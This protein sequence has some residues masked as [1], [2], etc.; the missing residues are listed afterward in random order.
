M[1]NGHIA[2]A[3]NLVARLMDVNGENSFRIKTYSNASFNIDKE[4]KK[5]AELSL[6]DIAAIKGV[7]ASTAQKIF[8]FIHTGKLDILEEYIAKTPAGIIEMLSIKGI[9]PKKINVI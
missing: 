9:G 1:D 2:D 7:G 5:I 8:D 6:A 4:Q 3:F